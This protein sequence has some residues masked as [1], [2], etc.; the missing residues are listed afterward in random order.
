[1]LGVPDAVDRAQVE[2]GGWA[3]AG[4]LAQCAIA[5]DDV[6]RDT[7]LLG[8]GARPAAQG[9]EERIVDRRIERYRGARFRR[10]LADDG[11]AQAHR[12]L[13]AQQRA[14][15]LGQAE[16][17][18]FVAGLGEEALSDELP[19]PV[20]DFVLAVILQQ[21]VSRELIVAPLHHAIVALPPQDG[22]AVSHAERLPDALHTV[23]DLLR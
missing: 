21:P 12:A 7:A 17:G 20:A 14:G 4:H 2:Q 13:A 18:I 6:R 8:R 3:G 9:L 5:E 22:D 15:G 23:A 11:L 1:K 16:D 10:A 19:D